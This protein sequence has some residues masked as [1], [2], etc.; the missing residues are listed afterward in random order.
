MGS[1]L[2][3]S[4]RLVD[5]SVSGLVGEL[6]ACLGVDIQAARTAPD[7]E[8]VRID[9]GGNDDVPLAFEVALATLRSLAPRKIG[10]G[11]LFCVLH[12]FENARVILSRVPGHAGSA[13]GLGGHDI[14]SVCCGDNTVDAGGEG[15]ESLTQALSARSSAYV[16]FGPGN[17]GKTG[18]GALAPGAAACRPSAAPARPGHRGAAA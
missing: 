9:Y 11:Q 8:L 10:R 15:V 6:D 18:T 16:W 4:V 1:Y 13:D 14:V 12:D 3:A 7:R 17:G 5:G 2:Q